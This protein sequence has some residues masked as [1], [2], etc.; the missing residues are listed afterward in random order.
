MK[1]GTRWHAIHSIVAHLSIAQVPG[2][3]KNQQEEWIACHCVP[4]ERK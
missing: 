3:K 1:T 2:L 4:W